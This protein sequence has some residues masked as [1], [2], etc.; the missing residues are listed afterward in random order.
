VRRSTIF[1]CF[2]FVVFFSINAGAQQPPSLRILFFH[3]EECDSC[4]SA[5]QSYLSTLK[6][7]YPFVEIESL[8]V[9]NPSNRELL[10]TLEKKLGRKGDDLPVAFVEDHV[11]S[12]EKEI[13][14]KLE[15]YVL[16]YQ[17]RKGLTQPPIGIPGSPN[18]S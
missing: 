6:S 5:L 8:D 16:E 10:G 11:L 1:A 14:E 4:E 12:G 13:T 9:R 17:I 18:P 15:L 3:A 7:T 2:V